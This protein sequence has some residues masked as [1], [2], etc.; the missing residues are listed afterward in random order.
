MCSKIQ[1]VPSNFVLRQ[2]IGLLL[3]SQPA[4]QHYFQMRSLLVV[5]ITR[6]RT[7][8]ELERLVPVASH[9][10]N[11][12]QLKKCG[13]LPRGAPRGFKERFVSLVRSREIQKA[14]AEIVERFAV[15]WIGIMPG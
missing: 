7:F 3:A 2:M 13:I 12:C 1:R 4:Q 11:P 5:P 15:R 6:Q 9:G 14:D 8:N 10:R